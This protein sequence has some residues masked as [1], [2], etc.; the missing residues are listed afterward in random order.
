MCDIVAPTDTYNLGYD[1][2]AKII[3]CIRLMLVAPS[4]YRSKGDRLLLLL[5][6]H[7]F[8]KIIA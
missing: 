8:L 4:I 3:I 7:P 5:K 2:I 1:I 6:L